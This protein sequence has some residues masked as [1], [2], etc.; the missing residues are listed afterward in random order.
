MISRRDLEFVLFEFLRVDELTRTERYEQHSRATFDAILDLSADIAEQHFASHNQSNDT[1]EPKLV[2]GVVEVNPDIKKAL[3]VLSRSG[4]MAATFDEEVGGLQLPETIAGACWMWLLAA[5]STTTAY[6]MLALGGANLLLAHGTPDDAREFVDPMIEGRFLGTMCLSEPQAGSSLGAIRTRAV[7]DEGRVHRL[8]GQKMWISGGD[9]NLTENIVHL[10]LARIDGGPEGSKGLSLFIVPKTL[11]DNGH[12]AQRNDVVCVGL[13]HKMGFRGTSNAV[14]SFGDGEYQ[15]DG[16]PGAVGYLV[17]EAGRGLSYMFHMMNESRIGVGACATAL[18]YT[19][20]LHALDYARTRE[21]GRRLTDDGDDEAEIPIIEHPDVKRMLLAQKSYVEGALA[22]NMYCRMLLDERRTAVD[23]DEVA[24]KN[25]LLGILTP[26]VKSWSAQWCLIANDL[27]IQ[28]HGGYGYTRDYPVEQFYRDNRLNPIHEG[29][30]GVQ[31]LDLLGRK[32]FQGDGFDLLMS[33]VRATIDR[34]AAAGSECVEFA[35]QLA[36]YVERIEACTALLRRCRDK[37]AAL[38][39]ATPYLEV[40]GHIVIGWIWLEQVLCA[41]G[42]TGDF[43]EGKRQAAR[44]FY[45]YEMPTVSYRIGFLE[46]LDRT[47]IEMAVEWF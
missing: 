2:D 5:N 20:Y 38:A 6:P 4:L 45:S 36:E 27:A 14:L 33:R 42:R 24:E 7:P 17:G 12:D 30:H 37:E 21:Q 10:V 25:S 46:S 11:S 1:I 18:G 29:T 31:A 22:L 26:I 9:H 44:Y 32:V 40:L 28:V 34:A 3:K 8:F 35:E 39:N 43:Y 13:N 16:R 41:D 15:P 23:P 47:T 19:G